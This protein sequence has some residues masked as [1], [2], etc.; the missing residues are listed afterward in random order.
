MPGDVLA[1]WRQKHALFSDPWQEAWSRLRSQNEGG[2][3]NLKKEVL[4]SVAA[5]QK[6]MSHGRVAQTLLV[7]VIIFI[8]NYR[9]I[10]R[11]RRATAHIPRKT[12]N[13]P[14]APVTDSSPTTI[15]ATRGPFEP[16][17]L[18]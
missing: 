11:F 15:P 12:T 18:E 1:K 7:A 9:A 4:D 6:R 5:P 3:G 13:R 14:S 17:P 2:N 16:P 10:K 8:S